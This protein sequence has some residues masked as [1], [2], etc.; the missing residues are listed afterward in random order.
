MCIYIYIQGLRGVGFRM[1]ALTNVP[2]ESYIHLPNP[3]VEPC[4]LLENQERDLKG[5]LTGDGP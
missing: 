5:I 2:K 3:M 1:G 4:I